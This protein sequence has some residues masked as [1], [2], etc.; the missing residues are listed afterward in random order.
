MSS[1]GVDDAGGDLSDQIPEE[2]VQPFSI[3]NSL[4]EEGDYRR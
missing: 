1:K 2:R 3:A 4:W